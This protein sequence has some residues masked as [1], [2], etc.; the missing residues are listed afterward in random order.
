M[1]YLRSSERNICRGRT[2]SHFELS[3]RLSALLD[4]R[5]RIPPLQILS[6]VLG[7]G[8]HRGRTNH[9]V[10]RNPFN[11]VQNVELR[12]ERCRH[13][14]SPYRLHRHLSIVDPLINPRLS[15]GGTPRRRSS[16]PFYGFKS[17]EGSA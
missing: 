12:L 10:L 5:I 4:Q 7:H 16:K 14:A 6:F 15:V 9:P 13:P 1:A 17:P 11:L 3:H 2:P 8:D